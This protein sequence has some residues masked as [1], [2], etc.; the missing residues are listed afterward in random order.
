LG[1]IGI[2]NMLFVYVQPGTVALKEIKI[3]VKRGI[4][5]KV[6]KPGLLFRKPFGMEFV[7]VFPNTLLVFEM[8]NFPDIE[9]RQ[10][11]VN[12]RADKAAHVQTSDGFFVD[13]DC[14]ILYR[15]VDP[16]KVI[17]IIGP[18]RLYED[19][20]IMPKAEPV[21]KQTLGQLTTEE[22]YNS[23]LRYSKAQ[24]A[25]D[26]LNDLL[27]PK[28]IKIEHLL[29]RYFVYS[30]EIQKNIEEKKLKD[31]LVFKNQSE[32]RAAIEE[33][34]LKR[35]TEEGKA[36]V[37]VKLQEGQAYITMKN[38]DKNLYIRQRQ[39]EADLLIKLAEAKKT[40]L[41]NEALRTRGSDRLVGLEMAK[42]LE[43]LEII[44]LP[45]DGNTG[46][47]PLDLRNSLVLF[48]VKK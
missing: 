26:Q 31:Q 17:R 46:L 33:A 10:N 20:G 40:E 32:G 3:G 48:E 43:G 47:N 28:G 7:H 34:K 18:G 9:S 11:E 36:S 13:V 29:V 37:K 14:T 42:V 15:I 12:Y 4:S 23:P 45:S 16:Y 19:N 1:I 6:H 27:E 30:D 22:F 41:K 39:A 8:T 35:M 44:I 2:Y 21:L 5:E 24:L 38:A 25:R